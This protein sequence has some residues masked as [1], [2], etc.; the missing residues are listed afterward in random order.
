[1]CSHTRYSRPHKPVPRNEK[2]IS[3]EGKNCSYEEDANKWTPGV[4]REE[5][6]ETEENETIEEHG[7]SK[8]HKRAVRAGRALGADIYLRREKAHDR[9][10]PHPRNEGRHG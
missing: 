7:E 6:V 10:G 9:R 3:C 4:R 1:M 2:K 5:H 8:E